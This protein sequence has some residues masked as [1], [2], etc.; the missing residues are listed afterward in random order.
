[1]MAQRK[2]RNN[3]RQV[4]LNERITQAELARKSGL[5]TTTI[6]KIYLRKSNG[7]PTTQGRIVDAIN[8]LSGQNY[9]EKEIFPSG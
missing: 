1:M 5:S 9:R 4:I 3:L 7:S 8:A 6:N 2:V